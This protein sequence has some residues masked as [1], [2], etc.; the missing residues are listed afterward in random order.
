METL[1]ANVDAVKMMRQATIT[2]K[3][4]RMREL[5]LRLWFAKI[6]FLFAAWVLNTNIE[7][8]SVGDN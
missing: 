2:V 6:A 1:S 8:E 4:K 7:I 5:R 3:V